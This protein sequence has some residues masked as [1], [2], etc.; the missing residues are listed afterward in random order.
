MNDIC[1]RIET[2]F[3]TLAA[4]GTVEMYS[5]TLEPSSDEEISALEVGLGAKLPEDVRT[6][7][8]RGLD[9]STGSV[10]EPFAAIGF[11]FLDAVRALEH[12]QMLRDN[13]DDDDDEE[14]G[15][16][17]RQG[18]ALTFEEPEIVVTPTGV[19]HFSFRNPLLRVA[20]TWSE[21]LEHWILSGAFASGDFAAAWEKTRPFIKNE[22]APEKNLWVTAYKKQFPG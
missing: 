20:S 8:S 7:L 10:S 19:Y 4:Q 16:V 17:I 13:A 2:F 1:E 22:I 14:H 3:K 18:V 21:F 6:W 5:E 12:T 9:G 11:S 15:D